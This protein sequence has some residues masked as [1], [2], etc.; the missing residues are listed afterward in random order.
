MMRILADENIPFV[1]DAF[2]SLGEVVTRAGRE[3]TRNDVRDADILLVRSVT[4]VN[5]TLLADSPVKFVAT[6]TI[7]TDHIDLDYLQQQKIGFSAA[8]G[9]NANSV[10]EYVMAALL[11][12]TGNERISLSGKVLGVVGV[13][14][15][16]SKV[17][18]YAE[19]LGMRVLQNDPPLARQTGESRFVPLDDLMPA[20]F[21]T[22]HVPLTRTGIDKTLHL[23]ELARL[24]KMKPGSVLINTSRGPVV[25]T[26]AA[27]EILKSGH[28][29]AMVLDVWENEPNIEIDLLKRVQLASPHIA[30]YSFDGK[31]NGTQMIYQAACDYFHQPV[32][33]NPQNAMPQPDQPEFRLNAANKSA[34]AVLNEAVRHAYAITADDARLR[35]IT[36]LSPAEQGA[37]FDRLRKDY[38]RRREFSNYRILLRNGTNTLAEKLIW[39]G[40]RV[41]LDSLKC[42]GTVRPDT[43]ISI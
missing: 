2:K 6:A 3:M 9:S 38:P 15:I 22:V 43:R 8:A 7:G 12:H 17:V 1:T 37:Y 33:W 19:K 20:D 28:L 31:V 23:F 36:R 10:A 11:H 34:E 21:I 26:D 29:K 40:F 18:H 30:G 13:G 35:E 25:A 5:E 14:H 41:I 4:K 27:R 16:G 39:L 42:R 32:N 24:K